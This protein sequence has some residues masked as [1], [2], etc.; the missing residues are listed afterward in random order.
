MKSTRWIS[1]VLCGAATSCAMHERVGGQHLAARAVPPPCQI[2]V[3]LDREDGDIL[4]D[5]EP[6]R[7]KRCTAASDKKVV[8][9][10][11]DEPSVFG[12]KFAAEGIKFTT[13]KNPYPPQDFPTN[14]QSSN[15][16]N[17]FTCEFA[18]PPASPGRIWAYTIRL[19]KRQHQPKETD[20]TVVND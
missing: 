16:G 9:W 15:G 18:Q 14:C 12:Y 6:V 17:K 11:I 3:Q 4:I 10:N 13:S 2:L 8:T 5:Y 7:T 1:L 20:P 19:E